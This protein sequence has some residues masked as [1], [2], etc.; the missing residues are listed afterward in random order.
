MGKN[1]RGWRRRCGV[2]LS[3]CLA[4]CAVGPDYR[5][6]DLT[7]PGRFAAS[8]GTPPAPV[9]GPPVARAAQWWT[10][11]GDPEL[12]SLVDRALSGNP[13]LAIALDRVQEARTQE[14]VLM[15]GLLPFAGASYGGGAGTGSDL[16][17]GRAAQTL[18]SADHS[19]GSL[20]QIG[21]LAGFDA[22]WEIDLFGRYRREM[23]AAR[24]D[25]QAVMAARDT[26]LIAVIADV[27]RAYVDF[28]GRKMQLAVLQKNIGTLQYYVRVTGERFQRGITNELD[29]TLAE[30]QLAALEA[31][32]APLEAQA[33]AVQYVIAVLLGKFPEDLAGELSKPALVPFL[34]EEIESGIPLDLLRNRPDVRAAERR[35][36]AAVARIGVAEMN[37]FP[38]VALN[39]GAGYQGPKAGS[40]GPWNAVWSW[41]P[42]VNWSILD[43]GA[44]DG[45]VD[46]AD[47]QAREALGGYKRTVLNAVREVDS[48]LV[49][50]R[51]EQER[52]RNLGVALTASQR[53]VT[54][55]TER[56]NR[57]LTDALNVVD[58][59][60][61][62]DDLENEYV[63]SQEAAAED[64]VSLYQAL[65]GGWQ[66]YQKFP[67][68][69]RPQPAVVAAFTRLLTSHQPEEK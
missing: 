41:G 59:E 35:A 33:L 26:V 52:L 16:S 51:G 36:A 57:G 68:I 2:L 9:P 50:Y 54:L 62:E 12:D 7:M 17:R 6:P 13:D 44:L 27:A 28:R 20:P 4:G 61:Q 14:I 37:L 47:L 34:P 1:S 67:P 8:H 21:Q 58:A 31:E 64:F 38:S 39:A 60:R 32:K 15:G 53:A 18:V 43:F 22:G 11:L 63:G 25:T 55:A 40:G 10:S 66:D 56:Y 69:R 65:G 3:C 30:R 45:L 19:G 48:A 49:A 29:V 23:E 5:T 46:I 42:S 24:Y